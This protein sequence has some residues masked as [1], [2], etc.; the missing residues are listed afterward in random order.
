MTP[1]QCILAEIPRE[2]KGKIKKLDFRGKI[3]YRYQPSG[4][5]AEWFKAHAWKVCVG[6]KLTASSNLAL[7]AISMKIISL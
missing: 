3:E 2:I 1:M 4:Q 5:V 6:L 7:S